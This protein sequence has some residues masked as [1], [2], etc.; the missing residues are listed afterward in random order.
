MKETYNPDIHHRRSIRLREYDYRNA[1]A[2]F[3]TICV[4][5]REC[6]F[7]EVVDGEMRLNGLGLAAE[8][9][10][11]AITNHFPNVQLDEFVIMPN[12]FHGI[13]DII[14]PVGAKQ[15]SSA[16]PGFGDNGIIDGDSCKGE[17]GEAFA[18]PLRD[19]TV[20]GSLGAILQNFKSVSTRKINKMRDN[21]GCPVWQR[22]YYEHVVRDETDLANIRKYIANN[23]LKWDLDENN[24]VNAGK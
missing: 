20:S 11:Q 17:A 9:C 7:G 8:A 12:H 1:G 5:Q 14:G 23:P 21:P 15:G 24:P 2:Y 13:M 6:L 18:S 19:G 10:W 22:N 4:F 3:V 16:S